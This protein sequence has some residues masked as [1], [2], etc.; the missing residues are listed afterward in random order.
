MTYANASETVAAWHQD[1]YRKRWMDSIP[2]WMRPARPNEPKPEYTH[3][4]IL[5]MRR[6]GRNVRDI[7]LHYGIGVHV[8]RAV[9][10]KYEE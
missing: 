5:M 3:S 2:E 7:A 4:S 10:R 1:A 6:A 8:V 9:L